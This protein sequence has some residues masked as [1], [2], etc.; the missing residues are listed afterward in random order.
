MGIRVQATGL[1]LGE[2]LEQAIENIDGFVYATGDEMREQGDIVIGNMTVGNPAAAP[3]AH[4]MSGEQ[5]LLVGIQQTAIG[6][7]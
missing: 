6:S 1:K 4:M 5:V 7:G 2:V 3:V